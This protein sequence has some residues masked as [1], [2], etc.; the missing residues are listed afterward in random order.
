M[1]IEWHIDGV[2]RLVIAEARG[3]LTGEEMLR[4]QREVWSRPDVAGY[5][6]LVDVSAVQDTEPSPKLVQELA[7]LSAAMD[8]ERGRSRFAI[9]A[10]QRA[11][12]GLARMYETYRGMENRSTTRVGVFRD[13]AQALLW[14]AAHDPPPEAGRA[15]PPG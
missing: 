3:T 12:Y 15:E 13:R 14:L 9:V 1:P 2:R 11:L 6:E 8:P 7:A 10:P 4:Y 5:D